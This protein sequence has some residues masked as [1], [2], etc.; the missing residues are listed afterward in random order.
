MPLTTTEVSICNSAL[1]KVGAERITSLSDTN[2]R[3]QLCDEQYD[4]IRDEV[5]RSHPWNFAIKRV[6]LTS[7]GTTPAFGYDYEYTIPT[8]VLRILSL[9]DNTIKWRVEANRK[10]LSDSATVK[11]EYIAQIT[12]AAEYDSYFAEALALRL[13]AE[14]AYPLVQS[15]R[16]Q[17]NLMQ[18]FEMHI[19][20]ARS[21]DAQEGTP[22]DLTDDGWIE[23]RL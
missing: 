5:L 21:F 17:E 13:A 6:E 4:K 12:A 16:L 22:W 20:N 19:R 15:I 7:T 23:T 1:I 10:L 14:L 8:D 9:H 2:K 11:I 18:R 3:A